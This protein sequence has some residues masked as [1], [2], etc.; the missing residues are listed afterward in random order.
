MLVGNS[1]WIDNVTNLNF[2]CFFFG[3]RGIAVSRLLFSLAVPDGA[4]DTITVG[5]SAV[6]M[7]YSVV[8]A[9]G[10]GAGSAEL[11]EVQEAIAWTSAWYA[12]RYRLQKSDGYPYLTETEHQLIQDRL[13]NMRVV[14]SV[15][16]FVDLYREVLAGNL[17][18]RKP[19][20][21]GYELNDREVKRLRRASRDLVGFHSPVVKEP[22][23]FIN[24]LELLHANL[25][26]EES[27]AETVYG[28][29]S[30]AVVHEL[31]HAVTSGMRQDRVVEQCLN[32]LTRQWND[33]QFDNPNEI[34]A[35][36]MELRYSL[37]VEP[38]HLFTL[39]EVR[40]LRA[41]AEQD[42]K[43]Y[44]QEVKGIGKVRIK[45]LRDLPVKGRI[46]DHQLFIRYT[47]EEIMR[48]LND[49]ADWPIRSRCLDS[50]I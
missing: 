2:L 16:P 42:T 38:G 35:R 1:L 22:N 41:R 13:R 25:R 5:E 47:D 18:L 39:K 24:P 48:L 26:W 46:L 12:A 15:A 14:L 6:P 7:T 21:P 33:G 19:L 27:R 40:A 23:V 29:L 4:T 43:A 44:K 20:K 31:T 8:L 17:H 50:E 9:E 32:P 36:V 30:K 34:Y 3:G 45:S 11:D 37:R 49:L 10:C 28:R